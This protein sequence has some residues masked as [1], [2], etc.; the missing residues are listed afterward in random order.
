MYAARQYPWSDLVKHLQ[1]HGICRVVVGHTPHGNCPTV[2]PH[3][4]ALLGICSGS[5]AM[6]NPRGLSVIMGDTSYSCMKSDLAYAGDNRGDAVCE[7]ALEGDTCFVRGR[8]GYVDG[9]SDFPASVVHYAAPGGCDGGGDPHIGIVQ[10]QSEEVPEDKRFFVKA[11]LAALEGYDA[12]YLLCKVDGFTNTYQE[13]S[14]DEVI[15]IFGSHSILPSNKT[16]REDITSF[17]EE[18]GAG[19]SGAEGDVD[20]DDDD[21]ES[22]DEMTFWH[23]E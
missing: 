10:P 12:R 5:C 13:E 18:F 17:G 23:K 7:I 19:F 1:D 20:D 22:E 6:L 8:T 11:C 2:I 16:T 4:G 9:L 15:R 21:D 3:E 14:P